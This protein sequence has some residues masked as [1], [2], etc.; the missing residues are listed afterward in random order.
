MIREPTACFESDCKEPPSVG[1][2]IHYR[3]QDRKVVKIRMSSTVRPIYARI[4]ICQDSRTP[5][6][7]R[8][9]GARR[10]KDQSVRVQ[11]ARLYYV[12]EPEE[13]GKSRRVQTA[14]ILVARRCCFECED[15]ET[16]LQSSTT[17]CLIH[18]PFPEEGRTKSGAQLASL[19]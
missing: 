5:A 11:T 19:Q 4:Y 14:V 16:S 15:G 10:K 6:K 1:W 2:V 17:T 9:C 12:P 18:R 3:S 13:A 7:L 8:W